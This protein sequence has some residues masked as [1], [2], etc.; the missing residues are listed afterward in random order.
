MAVLAAAGLL[1]YR[2]GLHAEAGLVPKRRGIQCSDLFRWLVIGSLAL[3]RG[4]RGVVD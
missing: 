2:V 3:G 4:A 1:L